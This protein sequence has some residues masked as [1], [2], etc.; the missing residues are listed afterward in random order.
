MLL[1]DMSSQSGG[2]GTAGSTFTKYTYPGTYSTAVR[3]NHPDLLV[4]DT[5]AQD[6]HSCDFQPD[7][8][9]KNFNKAEEV[10]TCELVNLSE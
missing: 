8:Q 9:I 10:W 4:S 3:A 7:H 5:L 6:F 1:S 2:T